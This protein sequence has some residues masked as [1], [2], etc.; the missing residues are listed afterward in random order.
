MA[1]SRHYNATFEMVDVHLAAGRGGKPA[2]IDATETLTYA[3]LAERTNRVANLMRTYG[4]AREAR[5][6]LLLLDT[7]DYPPAF[8]GAIKAGVVP[9]ALNTLLTAEQYAYILDDS[10]AQAIIVSAP[11]V[12]VI[13]RKSVV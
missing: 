6:A 3:G 8:W 10:R 13:D 4:I 5:V 7:V 1:Y 2:F 11:L 12:D 9:V